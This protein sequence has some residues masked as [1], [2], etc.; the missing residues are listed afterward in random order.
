MKHLE[1]LNLLCKYRKI[2]NEAYIRSKLISIPNELEEVG[3]FKRIG[4]YYYLNDSYKNFV[5]TILQRF[6]FDYIVEYLEKEIKRVEFLKEEFFNTSSLFVLEQLKNMVLKIFQTIQN[7]DKSLN[8][9]L[10]M[11][12]KDNKAS[13]DFLIK[14]AKRIVNDIEIASKNNIKIITIFDDLKSIPDLSSIIKDIKYDIVELNIRLDSYLKRLKDFIS[15]TERKRAFNQKLNRVAL[16]I[17]RE[18]KK[19][20]D[21]LINKDFVVSK[22]IEV[23]ADIIDSKKVNKIFNFTI[24]KEKKTSSK[25][26]E[27]KEVIELV[28]INKLIDFVKGSEDIYLSILEYLQFKKEL[29]N[30]SVRVFVYILN[31]YDKN[32][33]YSKEYNKYGVRI[34]KWK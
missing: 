27:L 21:I 29:L 31:N 16:M 12:E 7:R 5:N 34:V 18:D 14:E 3:L 4:N 17:L 24:Q 25:K 26:R 23:V 15:Q 11:L 2:I 32:L 30:E 10:N 28:D 13:L 22:K 8:S 1:F 20:D 9:V 6:D 33:V 19:I